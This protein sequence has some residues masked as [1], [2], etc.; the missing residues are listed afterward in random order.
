MFFAD[1]ITGMLGRACPRLSFHSGGEK[2]PL[3][4]RRYASYRWSSPSLRF[5]SHIFPHNGQ[6]QLGDWKVRL[7]LGNSS[8]RARSIGRDILI[9]QDSYSSVTHPQAAYHPVPFRSSPTPTIPHPTS[10]TPARFRTDSPQPILRLL[11]IPHR[12]PSHARAHS[13]SPRRA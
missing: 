11:Q 6:M 4:V 5:P 1:P 10:P 9:V 12:A 3:D 13:H 2:G 7:T 8:R